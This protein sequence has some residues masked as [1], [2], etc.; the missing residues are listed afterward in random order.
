MLEVKKGG[1]TMERITRTQILVIH[2][3]GKIYPATLLKIEND[4]FTVDIGLGPSII[5]RSEIEEGTWDIKFKDAREER[6]WNE[7]PATK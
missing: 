6:P 7:S 1:A 3:S 2:E 4:A 5:L